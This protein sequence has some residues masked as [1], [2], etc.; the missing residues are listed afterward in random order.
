MTKTKFVEIERYNRKSL[1]HFWRENK[2]KLPSLKN[3]PKLAS[4]KEL[5]ESSEKS[6]EVIGCYDT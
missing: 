1:L 4:C 2:K 5:K 3:S 6:V